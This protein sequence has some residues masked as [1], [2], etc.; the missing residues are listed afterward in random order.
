MKRK[1]EEE[2]RGLIDDGEHTPTGDEAFQIASV[3]CG[4]YPDFDSLEANAR[5]CS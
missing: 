4:T 5:A 1:Q 2:R 3:E